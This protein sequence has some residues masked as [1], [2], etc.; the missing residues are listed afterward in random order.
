MRFHPDSR[1]LG[2]RPSEHSTERCESLPSGRPAIR[3]H[4]RDDPRAGAYAVVGGYR[5]TSGEGPAKKDGGTVYAPFWPLQFT[6]AN[7][8]LVPTWTMTHSF[9]AVMGGFAFYDK[10]EKV[11]RPIHPTH[12]PTKVNQEFAFPAVSEED[13]KD[14][15]KGDGLTKTIA[16]VQLLWFAVQLIGRLI[17][18][19]AATELEVLTFAT[20]IMTVVIHFYWW[21]KPLDV[22]CQTILQLMQVVTD[23]VNPGTDA[24]KPEEGQEY[25]A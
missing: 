18:G 22:H 3:C 24:V 19:W 8:N 12:F 17:K 4:V 21:D 7:V 10:K 25:R 15:S 5:E 9:Y 14:K 2:F 11:Y 23:D 20:C 1:D 13:I 6:K 16:I